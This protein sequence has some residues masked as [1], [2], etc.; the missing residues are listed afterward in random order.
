M[1]I[2]C[3]SEYSA[4]DLPE[5]WEVI[6]ASIKAIYDHPKGGTGG[7]MHVVLDD[8][9]TDSVD[10]SLKHIAEQSA[11]TQKSGLKWYPDDLLELAKT[12]A[13][14]LKPLTEEQRG[15]VISRHWGYL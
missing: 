7:P 3:A 13:D 8:M 2:D 15:A 12:C 9:N 4:D 10:W 1:C 6:S 14:L 11:L 5:N